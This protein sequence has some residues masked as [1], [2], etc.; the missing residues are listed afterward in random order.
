MNQ[1]T[2][3]QI[4]NFKADRQLA[5]EV[6]IDSSFF[7]GHERVRIDNVKTIFKGVT[8][9]NVILE[10]YAESTGIYEDRYNGKCFKFIGENWI[11]SI[12][13]FSKNVLPRRQKRG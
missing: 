6:D 1:Y 8:T 9:S 13:Y 7:N 10:I 2:K 5:Y 4:G 3:D 12:S 11:R